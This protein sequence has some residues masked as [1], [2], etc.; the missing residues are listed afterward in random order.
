MIDNVLLSN[1]K[2]L[3][4]V[5]ALGFGLLALIQVVVKCVRSWLIIR[6]NCAINIQMG[7]NLFHHL[8]RLPLD[9]F[10]KRHI[11]DVVSRFG[12]LNTIR[13]VSYARNH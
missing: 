6:L 13:E 5:M 1:D 11:G 8:V 3:L 12:S 4:Q 10:E 9:Y 2:P 7:A